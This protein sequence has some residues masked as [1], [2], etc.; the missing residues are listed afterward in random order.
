MRRPTKPSGAVR[1]LLV[2]AVA[3]AGM[4]VTLPASPAAAAAPT[5]QPV[6]TAAV[7]DWACRPTAA[8]PTPVVLVHG[9][10][11]DSATL[12]RRLRGSLLAAGYCVFSINYG[13]R[14]TAPIEDSAAELRDVVDRVLAATGARKVSLV[15][16]SQGGM[17][18]RYY[19]RFLGGAAK[20][21][22]LVGL[23]PSN[24]GTRTPLLLTPGLSV[25]CP[26]C[27]QQ[28]AGSVFLQRLNAGDETPG[29][30][31]YTTVVTRYD[32]VVVP[33]TSGFLDGATNVVVQQKCRAHLPGHLL[34]PSD[35]VAVRVVLHALDRRGPAS[36]TYQPSCLP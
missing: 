18:P 23:A 4:L 12:L 36:P 8:R 25:L 24:H 5:A 17:M 21:D 3:L 10:F 15:G 29:A 34:L 7:N 31:S 2:V 9:T 26:A 33:Y 6:R 27:R 30:V 1:G 22:D 13:Q 35:G 14:A 16:H 32:E 28:A 11:G 20:V 19:L